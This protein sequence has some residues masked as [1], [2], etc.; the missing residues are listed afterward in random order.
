MS[1]WKHI[2]WTSSYMLSGYEIKKIWQF[3]SRLNSVIDRYVK[4]LRLC[5]VKDSVNYIAK[6]NFAFINITKQ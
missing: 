1:A 5:L 2:I 4:T 3:T 6:Y